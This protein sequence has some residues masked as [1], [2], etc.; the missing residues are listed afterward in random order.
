[1]EIN[2]WISNFMTHLR[3]FYINND[4][5][6]VY[7]DLSKEFEVAAADI[8]VFDRGNDRVYFSSNFEK[9]LSKY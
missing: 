7:N 4:L 6:F 5:A 1:M 8:T 3:N 2:K 9:L